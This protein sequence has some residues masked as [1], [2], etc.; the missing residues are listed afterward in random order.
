MA[1]TAQ[2]SGNNTITVADP[3][4]Q[5]MTV[6]LADGQNLVLDFNPA[7]VETMALND[8]G[9]LVVVFQNQ[10]VLVVENA[11]HLFNGTGEAQV[12]FADGQSVESFGIASSEAVAQ[13]EPAA[14]VEVIDSEAFGSATDGFSI[15]TSMDEAT[16]INAPEAGQQEVVELQ[17]GEE[18]QFTFAQDQ[19]QSVEE[20]GEQLVITFDDDGV[21]VIPNYSA[22]VEGDEDAAVVLNETGTPFSLAEAE[23]FLEL[24]QQMDQIEPA[25][26]EPGA[27][28]GAA[29]TGFGFGS[30]FTADPFETEPAIGVINPTALNYNAPEPELFVEI[31]ESSAPVGEPEIS[32]SDQIVF[33]DGSIDLQFDVQPANADESLSVTISGIDPS[34]TIDTTAS[35]GTYDAAAGTWTIDLP[36][37]QGLTQGPNFAPPADSD[38]DMPGLGISV[39]ATQS[40]TGDTATNRDGFDIITDAV[41]DLPPVTAKDATGAEDT[42]IPL[43]IT[44][45]LG[46]TDG[47]ESITSIVISDV[48]AGASLSAG[49]DQGSGNW[50][51]TQGDLAGLTITPPNDYSGS[52]PLTVTV[53]NE[54]TN[55]TDREVTLSNNE[56]SNRAQLTVTVEAV[57]DQ[58]DVE[59]S[60]VWVKEDGSVQLVVDAA[61]ND[62]DGSETL[63]V[64]ISGIDPSWGVDTSTSG[65]TYDAASGTW[66]LDLPSGTN[67]FTGGPVFSPSADSDADL[68][69]LTVSATATET[70]NGLSATADTTANIFTDAVVDA[71]TLTADDATGDE[72]TAIDLD[73]ATAVTD[74]D[75]SE[76]ITNI[77]ISG[78]PA[79]ASLSAGADLGGGQW[80]LDKSDLSGLQLTPAKDYN[81]TFDLTVDV[82]ATEVNLSGDE[83]DY[84]DNETTVSDTIS[85]TVTPVGDAPELAAKDLWVK[86]DSSVDLDITANL[87]GPAT[88]EL[89]VTVEGFDPTWDVDTST[90]G[91]TYDASTGA[92][93]ITLPAGEN[94]SGGP[95]VSPPADSDADMTDLT[96]TAT[97][98]DPLTDTSGTSNDGFDV[99]TDAVIDAP[100]LN[101]DD[102][103]GEQGTAIDLD[104]TTAVTDLDGSEEIVNVLIS[105]IPSDAGLSAG[106]D[107]GGGQW[108]LDKADLSGL[109]IITENDLAEGTYTLAV[110][111]TA[112][113]EN[114]SGNENDYTD[115]ETTVSDTLD[116]VINR[117]DVPK[118][119]TP[120][121][122]KVDETDFDTTDPLTVSGKVIADYFT[123]GP[124]TI[125]AT[126]E[127]SFNSSTALTS[128]GAAVTVAVVGNTYTGTANGETVFDLTVEANGDYTF[129]QY[130][131]LDHPD[132]NDNDDTITMEFGVTATDND[133]DTDASQI[134]I[135]VDDDGPRAED[136]VNSFDSEATTVATGN[137]VTGENGGP[138]AADDLS[139]DEA[140]LVTKIAFGG[141]EVDV[142][143]TGTATIEGDYGTLQIESDGSYAY[144]LKP[145]VEDGTSTT[146][147]HDFD[148]SVDFPTLTEGV[149]YTGTDALGVL[150]SDLTVGYE[151]TGSATFVSEGAGHSNS[152]GSYI[153]DPATGE[154]KSTDMMFTNGNNLAAGTSAGFDVPAGGGQLGFFI[155]ADG[156]DINNG[157]PGVD[158]SDG[159]LAFI[160]KTTG[161]TATINDS[162]EDIS[163]IFTDSAGNETELNGPVYHTTPRGEN[164]DLNPDDQVHV[165]SGAPEDG[166]T[167]TL[168]IGF[169]DLPNLG[170]TDYEDFIFD[171]K[172]DPA[173][174]NE[175]GDIKDAFT[176]TLTDG[177]GDSDDATLCL[178]TTVHPDDE[179]EIIR[180]DNVTVDE[181]DFDVS[182]TLTAS[183]QVVADYFNDGP[184]EVTASNNFNSSTTLTSNGAAVTVA[185]VG[186]DYVGT[187]NGETVFDLSL[188]T[189]GN[190]TFSQY[191]TLD[192]PDTTDHDDTI[193]LEFGVTATDAD[194]DTAD[195]MIKVNVDDDGL[196]ADDDFNSFDSEATTV[197]TGNVVTGENG[198]PGAADDLSNDEPN[199]VTKI[200]FGDT[201]VDVPETGTAT[202]EGDYGTLQIESDGSYAYTLDPD[203][204]DGFATT[205]EHDF[206][207]SVDFPDLSERVEYENSDAL[208][209]LQS[210]LDVS[211]ETTGSVSFVSEGAGY[212]NSFGS[213]IV[214]PETGEMK[215]TDMMFTNGNSLSAGAS[216]GFDVPAGGGQ[217]GFFIIANGYSL[218]DGYP[219]VDFSDGSLAFINKTTGDT[220]TINDNADDISLVFTDSAGNET[221]LSGPVY[222]TTSRGGDTDLNPDGKTHVVSGAPEDG[223][224]DTL[225]I[226]FEDLPRLGDTD[227]NDFIFDV[228]VD[229][230]TE[231]EGGDVKDAF[232]YTL[233]D[234]DGD[235]DDATL[236]LETKIDPNDDPV[237]TSVDNLVVDETDLTAGLV[238]VNG[239]VTADFF[240]DGP[241]SFAATGTGTFNASGSMTNG[242]LTSAGV[243]VVVAL[244]GNTYTGTA[245]GKKVFDLTVEDN[246]AY[247][248]NLYDT[249]DHADP[250]D[251]N[252]VIE[253]SFGV[254]ATDADGDTAEAQINVDVLDDAVIAHSDLNSFSGYVTEGDVI[255]GENGGPGAE[256]TLSQ[257]TPNVVT[258]VSFGDQTVDIPETGTARIDGNYGYLEMSADGDY[259]YVITEAGGDHMVRQ[260]NVKDP[261]SAVHNDKG[262]DIHEFDVKFDPVDN[263]FTMKLTVSDVDG[264]TTNG[265]TVAVNDGDNPKGY[266]G[267]M[268]MIYFDASGIDPAITIYGYNGLNAYSSYADG[269]S[270]SGTQA[271]DKIASSL[272]DADMF[273]Y[274][275]VTENDDGTRTLEF[276][277]DASAVMDHDP[278]YSDGSDW[279]GVGFD[280]TIGVW[281]HPMTDLDTEYGSD[282]FLSDW[283]YSASGWYD[284]ADKPTECIIVDGHEP[285]DIFEYTV[286]DGDGDTST[287]Y[288]AINRDIHT[289]DEVYIGQDGQEDS[290]AVQ[291]DGGIDL[292][293]GYNADDGD[294]VDISD[295]LNGYDP[296]AD[297]LS[298]FVKVD[299]VNDNAEIKV[300]A[301]GTTGEAFETVAVL[302]NAADFD[303]DDLVTESAVVV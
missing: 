161:D 190:Y 121:A 246:G 219:G 10:T 37:G 84:T 52:F 142:P 56:N 149:E 254:T 81:G 112:R 153:I 203:V 87:T 152:F 133:G 72:D 11:E 178:E 58:P 125:T 118:I 79:G 257:D 141:N 210:D 64:S 172:V 191:E 76:E 206:D 157:Y 73:I 196:R 9:A 65:G 26:G 119:I 93:T 98:Y 68:T 129:N 80:Q 271:A 294:T 16:L 113:E 289:E 245:D 46:D 17:R 179:P 247:N 89:T 29:N 14:G 139:N 195:G 71:P 284:V 5:S 261:G 249:L 70:S 57:P 156:Y 50:E 266:P 214:D 233:T 62:T 268:A 21:L 296:L 55:L 223:D 104:I 270:A 110:E 248:F 154:M 255:T 75:G 126:G 275:T 277:M 88:D 48:P 278:A 220:A 173:T 95:T 301:T 167:D 269:S 298:D 232:T 138:G 171:V 24:A 286:R 198:G 258:N 102:A 201:A 165:V 211:Y 205:Y 144:T 272:V 288:L 120:D 31:T 300:N 100:T 128:N 101:A 54:E 147:E 22:A 181:T 182:A 151:T 78:V 19:L 39:T 127:S 283:N 111:V 130:E 299:V 53:E 259:E 6:S 3:G 280:D 239:E 295:V 224:T 82:T 226:G 276:S 216:A 99:Y 36:E 90:S 273:D 279:S 92:W 212:S 66:S 114:L 49:T 35:G 250:N 262:G 200:A 140:N 180:V 63:T 236:C 108:Q 169:E 208:G 202:I 74:T 67:S 61:L 231:Y 97:A 228:A 163:L 160:N 215:S 285:T 20:Q 241:G 159:S 7:D 60:D 207:G 123:D 96:V 185:V 184:G 186:N 51:V 28:G 243:A 229:P 143:E 34:W 12:A 263:A 155:I 25:A 170:D 41:A 91:G 4:D 13:I 166:D 150:S 109:Q 83:N 117:D 2:M 44:A 222:H 192:H 187:A 238:S 274:I 105:G 290:F 1:N 106:T 189:D 115:N 230:A 135:K 218:N 194:G 45:A 199:L 244:V 287:A 43:D 227:Y 252:D 188:D 42:A 124:G 267:E 85:V 225:R 158:F 193:A 281:L 18:Y 293:V 297:A 86:E 240:N 146:H 122:K 23:Q 264:R 302:H 47:S 175:G 32:V 162:A 260:F 242:S 145:G 131:T 136:D 234:G 235:S 132:T 237:I 174:E 177:D 59:A 176:Y 183:G 27:G 282:G 38:A 137:V 77:V 292:F 164:S 251:P 256:D 40:G 204:T 148:G 103:N 168:R 116:L 107:L 134:T 15:E 8:D 33:E 303:I 265:F 213:Y 253:L 30:A 94:F 291:A 221:E 197:A 209:V 217:L 69:G